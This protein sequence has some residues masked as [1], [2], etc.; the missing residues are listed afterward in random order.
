MAYTVVIWQVELLSAALEEE[1]RLARA[2]DSRHKLTVE[3]LR[4][5]VIQLQVCFSATH[6]LLL[7]VHPD[8]ALPAH[9]MQWRAITI[10]CSTR[11]SILE[12][13]CQHENNQRTSMLVER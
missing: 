8:S 7:H 13:L 9:H 10:A 3:R 2:K 12:M 1:R 5:Q 4:R 11:Y 6:P